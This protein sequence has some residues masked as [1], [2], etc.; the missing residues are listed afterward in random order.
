MKYNRKK[1]VI[2]FNKI[3]FIHALTG[4]KF[5]TYIDHGW[6]LLSCFSWGGKAALN[7][8]LENKIVFFG[9]PLDGNE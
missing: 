1:A 2:H 7:V 3:K 9:F 4:K 8:L 6:S 5:C